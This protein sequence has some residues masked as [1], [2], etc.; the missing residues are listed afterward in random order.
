MM[1]LLECRRTFLGA[2]AIICLTGLGY[3]KDLDVSMA[4]AGV[5]ASV[6]ASNAYQGKKEE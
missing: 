6:A 1:K 3:T 4:L 5:V 2:L